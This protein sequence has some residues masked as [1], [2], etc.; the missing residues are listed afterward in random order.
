MSLVDSPDLA[1]ARPGDTSLVVDRSEDQRL[2]DERQ[3][4]VLDLVRNAAGGFN[5]AA[6]STFF[7]LIAI[8]VLNAGGWA[9]SLIAGG[10][11]LGFLFTPW[12]VQLVR[13]SQR[14]VTWAA[15]RLLMMAAGCSVVASLFRNQVVFM[16]GTTVGLALYGTVVPLQTAI[17]NRN[18]PDGRR[19][20]YVSVGILVRVV[21][22][23]VLALGVAEVLQRN[24]SDPTS[25]AWR[26]VPLGAAVA[27]AVQAIMVSRMPSGPLR[28]R[29][30]EPTNE[31]DAWRGRRSLMREDKLLRNVLWAW[32]WMG[33]ANLMML[34]LRVEYITN[35]VYGIALQPRMIVLITAIIPAIVKMM[36]TIPFG[37]AF[38]RLPFFAMRILVNVAFGVS[39]VAFF[40]GSSL[41]GLVIGSIT[42][43]IA[44]AGGDVLWN[45]WTTKFAPPG[46]V[47]DYMSLHTFF[48]GVRGILAPIVGFFLI[49][50]MSISAMGWICS[51]LIGFS[52]LMLVPYLR[53]EFA[54]RSV[55]A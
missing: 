4:R 2:D 31:R 44:A 53:Q 51:A 18:Y 6:E 9:K 3:T 35:P 26:I 21:F 55:S 42:F 28:L 49:T 22:T 7:L 1:G 8:S 30:D 12:V 11:G 32:M 24:L 48:T 17:F 37:W 19:G 13:N 40:I 52:S 45:L 39:I 20:H 47:A 27:Y 54:G 14:P 29:A 36:L 43:G 15:S 5:S 10:I 25:S 16:V 34:P 38:D 46:R 41:T 23:T 33:F 50:R